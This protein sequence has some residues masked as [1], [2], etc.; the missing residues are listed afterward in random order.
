M[1]RSTAQNKLSNSRPLLSFGPFV[2][3]VPP[4][5]RPTHVGMPPIAPSRLVL[6]TSTVPS[7]AE[8]S[9]FLS[10]LINNLQYNRLYKLRIRSVSLGERVLRIQRSIGHNSTSEKS[11]RFN[12]AGAR[13][14]VEGMRVPSALVPLVQRRLSS[15][16]SLAQPSSPIFIP[17]HTEV[18][19]RAALSNRFT[20]TQLGT[21]HPS[22]AFRTL[23]TDRT[24]LLVVRNKALQRIVGRLKRIDRGITVQCCRLAITSRRDRI[25]SGLT[26]S[27]VDSVTDAQDHRS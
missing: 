23:Q 1:L 18:V 7:C 19:S 5:P 8:L 3:R 21:K 6:L 15:C 27:F 2:F 11:L 13:S 22:L 17:G 12:G 10:A 16:Y 14:D 4:T 25:I 20:G 26:R 24:A 9:M